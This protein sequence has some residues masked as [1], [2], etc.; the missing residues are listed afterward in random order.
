MPNKPLEL[1][2]G[3]HTVVIDTNIVLD[4]FIFDDKASKPLQPALASGQLRWL[5]TQHMRNEL[6]RV[7]DYAHI[8]P[9]LAYYQLSKAD[10]LARFDRYATLVEVAPRVTA[11]CKDPD[12]QC[13]I[14]LAV[15]HQALLL[16]KDKAVLSMKKR[17][18]ALG[19]SAQAAIQFVA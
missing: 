6:E 14:D 7:L 15:A 5:A 19:T 9:K 16:S 13:F 2:A 10:V 3:P 1:G 11:I 12:D 4:V 18:L 8:V 17:L